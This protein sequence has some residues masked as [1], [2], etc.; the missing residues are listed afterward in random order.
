MNQVLDYSGP[1]LRQAQPLLPAVL[2]ALVGCPAASAAAAAFG[3][4]ASHSNP[5][6]GA[7][8]GAALG[9]VGGSLVVGLA[10]LF[11]RHALRVSIVGSAVVTVAVGAAVAVLAEMAGA[12]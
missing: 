5:R 7:T 6:E 12:C 1:T 3:A 9:V 4:A 8:G 2:I 11:R 10:S